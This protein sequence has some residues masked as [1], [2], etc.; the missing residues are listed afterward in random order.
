VRGSEGN[1]SNEEDVILMAAKRP[2]DV[3]LMA[4]KRPEDLLFTGPPKAG[5]PLAT[6]ASG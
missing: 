5:P 3:I 1:I 4:A 2:E 6:L